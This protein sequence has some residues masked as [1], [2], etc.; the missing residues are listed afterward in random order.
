MTRLVLP[1]PPSINHYWR[2]VKIGKSIRTLISAEGREYKNAVAAACVEQKAPRGLKG[3]I[4]M[5]IKL[6]PPDKRRRD[7]DNVLKAVCDSLTYAHV[8]DDDSQIDD[9]RIYR[10]SCM[11][12][13]QAVID[14]YE[15]QSVTDAR[16][17]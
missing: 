9:L 7:I 5:T 10:D 12:D 14:I 2:H 13:G 6:S 15:I 3:R 1:W 4:A 11:Q 8:W 16:G 17:R